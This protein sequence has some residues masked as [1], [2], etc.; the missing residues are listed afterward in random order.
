M[1]GKTY[2]SKDIPQLKWAGLIGL[3]V[4]P[5]AWWFIVLHVIGPRLL[6][7]ITTPD[8][9]IN[10]YALNL[11]SLSCYLFEFLLAVFVLRREGQTFTWAALRNR[12]NFRWGGWK[13]WAMFTILVVAGVALTFPLIPTSKITAQ[14]APPPD[15]FPASQN[16]LKE[17]KSVEDALPGVEFRGN[18]LFLALFLFTGVMNIL[19]EDALYRGVLI[20]KSHG[21][22]GKRAWLAGGLIFSLK[23]IYVW[24]RIQET[25]PLAIAGAY[26]FG[27]MGSL[28]FAMLAHFLGNFGM[29]WPMVIKKV[30]FG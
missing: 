13:A 1:T 16:P 8:G 30:L 9:E 24:W 4:L 28:P 3:F 11:I 23:H 18:Y 2:D 7:S 14:V 20:P 5:V 6:S 12:L 21:L 17:V 26:M 19:G 27:P 22:F 10:G 29:T 25:L 15:W